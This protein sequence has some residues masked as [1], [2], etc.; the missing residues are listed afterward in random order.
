MVVEISDIFGQVLASPEKH[1]VAD[2]TLVIFTSDYEGMHIT[3]EYQKMIREG[4]E[5]TMELQGHHPSGPYR[6]LLSPT[7]R[8]EDTA[9]RVSI[10]G[11]V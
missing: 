5:K 11:P 1:G 7:P 3:L 4:R 8:T 6:G 9:F 10:A 2:N